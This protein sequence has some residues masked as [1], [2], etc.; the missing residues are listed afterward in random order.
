MAHISLLQEILAV[1]RGREFNVVEDLSP[2]IPDAS[3][4]VIEAT[5]IGAIRWG[6]LS[7]R[8]NEQRLSDGPTVTVSYIRG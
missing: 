4:H 2:H 6:L 1:C 3:L 7:G 8:I 5:V